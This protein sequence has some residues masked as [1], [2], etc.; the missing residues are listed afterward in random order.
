MSLQGFNQADLWF[1]DDGDYLVDAAGD[2]KDTKDSGDQYEGVR[3]QILHRVVSE[4][5]GL[6]LHP[7]IQAGLE[8]FIGKTVDKIL[9]ERIQYEIYRALTSDSAL[10]R[11]DFIIKT[12]EFIP[13][14]IAIL[15]YVNLPG[16]S[17]PLVVMSWHVESGSVTRVK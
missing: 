14:S 3:Q 13:G 2:L 4:K 7:N 15:I 16:Q 17:H 5:N 6:R 10:T 12:V 1:T 11:E 9:Q 8:R